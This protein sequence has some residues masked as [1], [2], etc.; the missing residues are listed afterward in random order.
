MS[1]L[2]KI[3]EDIN[4][5]KYGR[6]GILDGKLVDMNDIPQEMF[7]P[8]TEPMSDNIKKYSL[9]NALKIENSLVEGITVEVTSPNFHIFKKDRTHV[10][11]SVDGMPNKD[12]FEAGMVS[13]Y[14]Q[15]CPSPK[16]DQILYRYTNTRGYLWT[17][18]KGT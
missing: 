2:E 1:D 16:K 15:G 5:L 14:G 9:A 8:D 6:P 17:N 12:D 7:D 18:E 11:Y 3:R 10:V 13:Y 4:I